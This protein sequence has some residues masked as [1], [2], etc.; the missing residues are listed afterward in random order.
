MLDEIKNNDLIITNNKLS[1]LKYLSKNKK[2][3]NL[4]IM[5]LKEFKDKYFGYYNEEAIYYLVNKYNYKYDV[6]KLYLDNFLF[7]DD[8]KQEL[9]D[10]NLIIKEPLFKESIK[11]IVN[12][13]LNI[14]PFIQKE[15]DKFDNIRISNKNNKNIP[16]VYEFKTLEEEVNFICIE[17][18]KLLKKID[19]NKIFLINI[20]EEYETSIKRMFDFYNIPINLDNK[21]N[22]YGTISVQK[23]LDELKNTKSIELALEKIE[24]DEIYDS[25][26]DVCN[27]YSFKQL[28]DTII[29]LI[30]ETL[31]QTKLKYKKLKNAIN[32]SSIY[33]I[34][35]NN[36]YFVLGFNQGIIPKIYKNEDYFSDSKKQELGM[37]TSL[38]K[39]IQ[40]KEFIKNIISNYKNLTIT[41]KLKS[42]KED[43][44]KSSLI[45][46]MNLE[47]KTTEEN[48][49]N[50][51]NIY[52]KIMLSKKLDRLIKFNEKPN[53]L[54]ILYSNYKDIPYLTYDNNY[55]KI[56]KELFLNQIN[57]ELLLSY[58]SIDNYYRCSFRYYINNILKLNKYEETFMT[59]IGNLFHYIL[60]IA[61]KENFDFE[62]EFKD[63]IKEKEFSNKEKFFIN[64]LKKD[65]L[66][67]IETIKN[68]DNYTELNNTLYEEK[69]YINKDNNIKITFMGIIDKLKYENINGKTIVAI[70]DYKTG[71]PEIDLN[72]MYYGISMQLPIYL[73][74]A[75]NSSLKNIEIAG[76]YLQKVIHSKLAYQENKDYNIELSKLY[77]LEG[78]SN[79]NE[80]IL[81]KF[82]KSYNDS[83]MIKGMKTSSKG[84]YAYSKVLN[85]EQINNINNLV[86]N[87]INEAINN[88]LETNFDINPKRIGTNLKGCEY[89]KFK[90]ICYMKEENIISLEEKNYKDF[91]GGEIDA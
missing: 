49:Y 5:S 47:I 69:I 6:A 14:D 46:E 58:S 24:K 31:K 82:D 52:N 55:K 76:F 70:I 44:Y 71:N 68:Q 62:K 23:F 53:D 1:I 35:D 36:Y 38:Q 7:I 60:S 48:T 63:Y 32:I 13:N 33:E 90:D 80:E 78:Y 11:R 54:N 12:D 16:F 30:E 42:Y 20:S 40:E 9:I 74:L 28:D 17:I 34:E 26:V 4:K 66:F 64:K 59:F 61:F 8:L 91:L 51:S 83:L 41:Y 18:L 75:N 29:Y 77:R 81:S 56:D 86:D 85:N 43:Y 89:C 87:K 15:I 25:I 2:L 57:N 10:N 73:Y 22:I 65:L 88:I 67:T 37:F 19:I 72:N 39:N 27:K 45:N 79:N 21:K 50:Y 84:F 3:L